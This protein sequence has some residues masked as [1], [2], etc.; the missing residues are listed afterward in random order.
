MRITELERELADARASQ[1]SLEGSNSRQLDTYRSQIKT[2][3]KEIAELHAAHE[4]HHHK[5][6]IHVTKVTELENQ[7]GEAKSKHEH[8]EHHHR[9]HTTRIKELEKQLGEH[10]STHESHLQQHGAHRG[11]IQDLQHQ[12]G[13]FQLMESNHNRQHGVHRTR[14]AELEQELMNAR[15]SE[16]NHAKQ[17]SG[18]RLRVSELEQALADAQ[19]KESTDASHLSTHRARVQELEHEVIGVRQAEET[20]ARQ[21][22]M[23]KAKNADLERQIEE[24]RINEAD[25]GR[26]HATN[27][28]KVADLESTL[29]EVQAAHDGH[30]H[31]NN[32]HRDN[33]MDLERRLA[34]AMS[35]KEGMSRQHSSAVSELETF[36]RADQ[37]HQ[38][39]HANNKRRIAELEQLLA[40]ME[41][42]HLEHQRKHD[43]NSSALA[44]MQNALS[45]KDEA[46]SL[47]ILELQDAHGRSKDG[48]QSAFSELQ[49]E[50]N[51]AHREAGHHREKHILRI[52]ELER[53]EQKSQELRVQMATSH[54]EKILVLTQELSEERE[55]LAIARRELEVAKRALE[56]MQQDVEEALAAQEKVR[57]SRTIEWQEKLDQAY[58]QIRDLEDQLERAN[59]RVSVTAALPPP[60]RS[61]RESSSTMTTRETITTASRRSN[62]SNIMNARPSLVADVSV[63]RLVGE[64]L[65]GSGD[66][67]IQKVRSSAS[68]VVD[69]LN[70]ASEVHVK[71]IGGQ[72][73]NALEARSV[74]GD[75]RTSV[76]DYP[77][78][79]ELESE[80]RATADI[81][82]SAIFD[83]K[84]LREELAIQHHLL[85]EEQSEIQGRIDL[86]IS[87]CEEELQLLRSTS[88]LGDIPD[89]TLATLA[90]VHSTGFSRDWGADATPMH[91]AAK[92]GRRDIIEYL[93]RMDGG[94]SMLNVRDKKGRTP[95]CYAQK[96]KRNALSHWLTVEIGNG[97]TPL[98][99]SQNRPDLNAVP[100]QY[101]KVLQQIEAH[102]WD[103]MNWKDGFTMLHWATDKGH[104]DLCRYL[105]QLD[106]DPNTRDNR[107]R[108]AVDV[109]TERGNHQ[110]LPVL[111]VPMSGRSS[112]VGVNPSW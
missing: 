20:Q 5:H 10:Q 2:L 35:A 89:N 30:A 90:E 17:S 111:T 42:T 21:L 29:A 34:D 48:H 28:N 95:A 85:P 70:Q 84:A 49:Q 16:S 69:A 110:L 6:K 14:I 33:V 60:T 87:R 50:L 26:K 51:A 27:R 105:V 103:S 7:L 45:Q 32:R 18:H 79:Y 12:L 91:W 31:Q 76:S 40:D 67:F 71:I 97:S 63:R 65:P 102:G 83:L 86:D 101:M 93:L 25:H 73:A 57:R 53:A 23:L 62:A 56:T 11:Q 106:A 59:S 22:Q 47:Q 39:A 68:V 13:E 82:E 92:N 41:Q 109:A 61:G 58:A 38:Q 55:A 66:P 100:E 74:G 72:M 46:H 24:H 4:H 104:V 15:G 107:G 75:V 3:E 94:S 8:H 64:I 52:E 44:A 78:K 19:A 36:R 37:D 80:R 43:Q 54:E 88:A 77:K 96:T 9:M 108:S 98:H 81:M 99:T 1:L 112:R